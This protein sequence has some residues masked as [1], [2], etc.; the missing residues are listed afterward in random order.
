MPYVRRRGSHLAIV[1]GSRHPDTKKVEQ[2]VL[3]TLHSKAEALA[4]MG[5]AKQARCGDF[6]ALVEHRY[7]EVRFDWATIDAAIAEQMGDLPDLAKS[8]EARATGGFEDALQT[9]A[10]YVIEADPQTLDSARELFTANRA[11]LEWLTDLLDTRLARTDSSTPNEWSR[12]PFGWR[13]ALSNG[14]MDGELEEQV[15]D[16]L[17]DGRE[18]EAEPIFE[19]LVRVYPRYAEGWNYLGLIALNRNDL[20]GALERFERCEEVG[21]RLFPKRIAKRDYGTRLE[22]RPY[23]RGL[24]NQF[25]PLS[26]LGRHTQ[27][28][29]IA[30][31]LATECGDDITAATFRATAYLNLGEWKLAREAAKFTSDLSPESSFV[32]ALAAFE[33]GDLQEAR[34]R[35]LHAALSFPLTAAM[36]LGRRAAT[37]KSWEEGRD[38]STGKSLVAD[39]S[40]YP[41]VRSKGARAFFRDLLD[42]ERVSALGR[43]RRKH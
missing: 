1:H 32:I 31:R 24:Q 22:T 8:R 5:R 2:Q 7:P 25:F 15:A 3:V 12:D 29:R 28:L 39:L 21:R 11:V 19:F 38:H 20:A 16:M 13:L 23:M 33:L 17:N 26:R 41:K 18:D 6:H 4:A 27:A 10:R 30:E 14:Q 37:P 9:F 34:G 43:D 36:L 40:G 35:F 42:D